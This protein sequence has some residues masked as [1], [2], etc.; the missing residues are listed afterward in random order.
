MGFL[1]QPPTQNTFVLLNTL[2]PESSVAAVF[3]CGLLLVVSMLALEKKWRQVV[4]VIERDFGSESKI[5][6]DAILAAIIA[7]FLLSVQGIVIFKT[8][9]IL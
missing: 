1:Q 9:K 6:S 5:F 3:H 4:I 8:L 2:L 7:W